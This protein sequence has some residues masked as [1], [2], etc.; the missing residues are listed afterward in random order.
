MSRQHCFLIVILCLRL[1]QS[2]SSFTMIPEPWE[3]EEVWCRCSVYGWTFH[4]LCILSCCGSV[5]ITIYWRKK[6]LWWELKN[7][8]ISDYKDKSLGDSLILY[9]L[10]RIIVLNSQ[11]GP[12]I[13]LSTGLGHE[14]GDRY[15]FHL[16]EQTSNPIRNCLV[17]PLAFVPSVP[18]QASHHC[19]SQIWKLGKIDDFFS[20]LLNV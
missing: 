13:C 15:G 6:L 1:L 20:P 4:S 7:V 2:V 14:N 19:S 16:I 8:L 9:K 11:V 18:G 3:S 17:T 10:N 12:M 5:Y